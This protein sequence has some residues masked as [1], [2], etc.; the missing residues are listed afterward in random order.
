[1]V[2]LEGQLFLVNLQTHSRAI[3]D[4]PIPHHRGTDHGGNEEQ[5]DD[6]GEVCSGED[7]GPVYLPLASLQA[8]PGQA[9]MTCSLGRGDTLTRS[10]AGETKLYFIE[11]RVSIRHI[12]SNV[13]VKLLE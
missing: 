5:E 12:M 8:G 11:Y 13:G 1:M 4:E 9:G 2:K 7:C 6:Q 3:P 10:R